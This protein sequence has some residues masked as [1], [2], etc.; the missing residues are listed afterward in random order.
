MNQMKEIH[1]MVKKKKAVHT[2]FLYYRAE[3]VNLLYKGLESKQFKLCD[4]YET[5]AWFVCLND[6]TLPLYH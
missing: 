4:S 3:S 2:D 6:A 5:H 1:F